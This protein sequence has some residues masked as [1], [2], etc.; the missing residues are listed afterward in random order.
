MR[1][2]ERDDELRGSAALAL[3]VLCDTRTESWTADISADI[4][5]NLLTWTLRDPFGDGLGV[6]DMR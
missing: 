1:D 2:S 3:G 6:L 4:N 5:Y